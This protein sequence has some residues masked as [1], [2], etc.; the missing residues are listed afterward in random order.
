MPI[1]ISDALLCDVAIKVID[2]NIRVYT[3]KQDCI[4]D[5][6]ELPKPIHV[7]SQENDGSVVIHAT[8]ELFDINVLAEKLANEWESKGCNVNRHY[9][10]LGCWCMVE[11]FV[12]R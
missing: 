11:S 1:D 4:E 12:I 5:C 6:L 3:Q 8:S 7:K 9:N 2:D 10:Y